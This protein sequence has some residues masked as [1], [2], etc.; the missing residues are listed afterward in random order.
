M[1]WTISWFLFYI[2]FVICTE[3]LPFHSSSHHDIIE[4]AVEC[5]ACI[6][7]RVSPSQKASMVTL[8]KQHLKCITLAI[9]D[10]ANDVSMIQAADVGIGITG[11]EGLQAARAA[12]YTIAQFKFLKRLLFVHGH[13]SYRRLSK[14]ILYSFYKTLTLYL[15]SFYFSFLNG[16]SGQLPWDRISNTLWNVI[17]TFLAVIVLGIFEQDVTQDKLMTNPL[18]YTAGHRNDFVGV[19][20]FIFK[21]FFFYNPLPSFCLQFNLKVFLGWFFNSIYHSIVSGSFSILLEKQEITDFLFFFFQDCVCSCGRFFLPRHI[22]FRGRARSRYLRLGNC[23]LRL[24]SPSCHRKN[25]FGHS[26]LDDMES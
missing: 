25:L 16:F 18:L 6:C 8:V 17:Y 15:V 24:R 13:L 4:L 23:S 5:E 2:Y 7:C 14:V 9:G 3:L 19:F 11:L 20:S 26:V 10:G 22:L 1:P 12:D 21:V